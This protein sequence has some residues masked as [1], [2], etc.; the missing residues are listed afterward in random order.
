MKRSKIVLAVELNA[1]YDDAIEWDKAI[2]DT[3]RSLADEEAAKH[4]GYVLMTPEPRLDVRTA[5]HILLPGVKVYL[6]Y[7][8][9]FA[10]VEDS[11][12]VPTA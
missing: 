10:M 5:E 7:S 4:G 9:W 2:V 3:V 8:E 1:T 6:V 12:P 11:A